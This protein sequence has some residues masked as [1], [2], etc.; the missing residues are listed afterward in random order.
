MKKITSTI[1]VLSF[2]FCNQQISNARLTT[3]CKVPAQTKTIK[4]VSYVCSKIGNKL[5]WQK[6][7]KQNVNNLDNIDKNITKSETITTSDIS[8]NNNEKTESISA[9]DNVNIDA[10]TIDT[11]KNSNPSLFLNTNECKLK[12]N[13]VENYYTT[14]GFPRPT[15]RLSNTGTVRGIL[16][17][18]EF[19]DVKGDD[20]PIVE[21]PKFTDNFEKF[22][23]SVSYNKLN[24]KVDVHPKYVYIE[25]NS[26][27]YGMNKWGQGN[28]VQYFEDGLK[29]SDPFVNFSPYEFVVFIPPSKIK[30]IIF[31]PA[32][33]FSPLHSNGYTKER[34]I[35]NGILGGADQRNSLKTKWIWLGHEIGHAL[36]MHHAY[37]SKE[38]KPVWDLMDNVYTDEAPELFGW[39]RF[40]Q[41]WLDQSNVMCIS[42]DLS[43]EKNIVVNLTALTKVDSSPKILI[44]T[45]SSNKALVVEVRKRLGFDIF[46]FSNEGILPYIVEVTKDGDEGAFSIVGRDSSRFG[47][48]KV[49]NEVSSHNLLISNINKSDDGFFVKI[50]KT[51]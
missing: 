26:S 15:Y 31:G 41:G 22:Y 9:K 27:D 37:N 20:D 28:A 25:K 42:A 10:K 23:K 39:Q 11:P 35:Y 16:I 43:G 49:G 36:G 12:S 5:I 19:K 48:V 1:L 6:V 51:L 14:F 33:L 50:E 44:I 32:V 47:T 13:K 3:K 17:F 24:F 2:I 45:L 21:G 30:E 34:I 7:K 18:V 38:N 46:D 40:L 29:F 8:V 4:N